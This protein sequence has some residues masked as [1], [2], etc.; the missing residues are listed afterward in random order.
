MLRRN[1]TLSNN[2]KLH[3]KR[4]EFLVVGGRIQKRGVRN[5]NFV[6]LPDTDCGGG[7]GGTTCLATIHSHQHRRQELRPLVTNDPNTPCARVAVVL[8]KL[9]HCPGVTRQNNSADSRD[10]FRYQRLIEN[11]FLWWNSSEYIGRQFV[12]TRPR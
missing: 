9:I 3:P 11:R 7:C 4:V 12:T 10:N 2:Q 8:I 1:N 6:T 5:E